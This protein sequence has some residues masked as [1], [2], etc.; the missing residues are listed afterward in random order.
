[1]DP[2]SAIGVAAAVVGFV[3]FSLTLI[4]NGRKFM[5]DRSDTT[6]ESNLAGLQRMTTQLTSV[7]GNIQAAPGYPQFEPT[8][9]SGDPQPVPGPVGLVMDINKRCAK[10]HSKMVLLSARIVDSKRG[11]GPSWF[12]LGLVSVF[13]PIIPSDDDREVLLGSIF[14][15]MDDLQKELKLIREETMHLCLGLLW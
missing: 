1:M 4:K 5:R 8:S 11:R 6:M 7:I 12:K 15:N 13:R 10:A 9:S 14:K 3:D 2:I